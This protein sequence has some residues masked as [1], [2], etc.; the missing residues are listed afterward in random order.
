M[1][2][3][4]KAKKWPQHLIGVSRVDNE[5]EAPLTIEEILLSRS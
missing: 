2:K 5:D 3:S 4:D 1:L